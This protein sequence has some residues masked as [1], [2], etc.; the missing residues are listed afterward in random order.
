[1][2]RTSKYANMNAHDLAEETRNRG[3]EKPDVLTISDWANWLEEQDKAEGNPDQYVRA[4]K[5][6]E[7]AEPEAP[8]RE[9]WQGD[10]PDSSGGSYSGY[11]VK[12]LRALAKERNVDLSGLNDRASIIDALQASDGMTE[13]QQA[14]QD[15]EGDNG[16]H[17]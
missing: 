13:D 11:T 10:V 4:R 9:S 16:A 17:G 14:A 5:E 2:K 7:T 6:G 15:S 12:E 8:A 3:L 1:M